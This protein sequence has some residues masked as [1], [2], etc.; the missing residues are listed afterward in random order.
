MAYD[1][2]MTTDSTNTLALSAG[3][4]WRFGV[5]AKYAYRKNLDLGV[6][7]EFLW[8]GSP[9]VDANRGPLAGQVSGNYNSSWIQFLALNATWK[10]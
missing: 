6:A 3:A 10:F 2:N 8:S 9:S 4:A 1:S 7:Y 5:G